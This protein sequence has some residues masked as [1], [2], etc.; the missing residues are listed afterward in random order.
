MKMANNRNIGSELRALSRY[1]RLTPFHSIYYV[2]SYEAAKSH[3]NSLANHWSSTENSSNNSWNMNFNDGN[4]NNNNKNNQNV[5]RP[6]VAYRTKSKTWLE[7]RET[8][9]TAYH[10]CCRGKRDG[11]QYLDYLPNANEDL[12]LLTT[13]LM[14]RTYK[15]STSTC[16]LVKFPKL[17]EVFAAAFRDRIIHHWMCL[18]LVPLFE[19]LNHSIGD[20]T[21]NCRVGYGTKSAVDSVYKA[22]KR[23]TYSYGREAYI[24]RGDLVG[25]FMSLPQR[26]MCDKLTAFTQTNYKGD[27]KDLLLWLLEVVVMHRPEKNCMLNSKPS[28]WI[29]LAAN[30]S[31]FRTDPGK[32]SPIGNL[33]TQQYANFY[34]AEDFDLYMVEKIEEVTKPGVKASYD[35]FVDDFVIVCSDLPTLQYLIECADKRI[36]EIGLQMHKDKRYLQPASHGVMFVGSYLKNGRI[37]LSNRT[38]GRFKDK[39]S[40]IYEYFN[41][42]DVQVTSYDLEHILAT[43]NSYLGFCKDKQTYRLRRKI[44]RPL[45][46]LPGFMKYYTINEQGTK[47][48]LK[49]KHKTII[50]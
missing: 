22:I 27:F 49:K 30:K 29:G 50:T 16:F 4:I 47:V 48:T 46:Y 13:E 9:Q 23:I 5:V 1:G 18:R 38:L 12:D 28:D 20:V 10:D 24:F 36:S 25:F 43:L 14:E 45:K 35:R 17:R 7:L 2:R 41:N 26:R 15:P 19:K 31:L 42:P 40:Q 3:K 39:V 37:Y 32:G 33:T 8:I 21:H 44:M 6:S 34:L 11:R